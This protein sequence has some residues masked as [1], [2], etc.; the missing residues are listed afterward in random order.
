MA[1]HKVVVTDEC[2]A[3]N[4]CVATC[5][6]NFDMNEDNTKAI[7]KKDIID[8]SELEKNE[9]AKEI[10]PTEAIKIEIIED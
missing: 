7:V 3:C 10:C 8:D 1:K 5:E 6:E 2:I 9:E 4:A